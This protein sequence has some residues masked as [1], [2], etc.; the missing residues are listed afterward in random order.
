MAQ[1]N[2]AEIV[3]TQRLAIQSTYSEARTRENSPKAQKA[4]V[5]S[6]ATAPQS[7]PQLPA[8]R[9]TTEFQT[10]HKPRWPAASQADSLHECQ[11]SHAQT[12]ETE[13]HTLPP[14]AHSEA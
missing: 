3:S 13:C 8:P 10:I 14:H 11:S 4:N 12:Q 2:S 6:Q 1:K 9:A 5:P 7:S